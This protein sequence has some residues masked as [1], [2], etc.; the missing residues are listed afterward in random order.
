MRVAFLSVKS[1]QAVALRRRLIDAGHCLS[2]CETLDDLV[3]A[4]SSDSYD[5]LVVIEQTVDER[6]L[7]QVAS[8]RGQR[9]L[10]IPLILITPQQGE[11][12]VVRALN[13]GADDYMASPVREAE[14]LARLEALTRRTWHSPTM[15]RPIQ[16]GR[17]H[18]DLEIRRILLDGAPLQMTVKDFDLAVLLL[19][20]VGRLIS[21]ARIAQTVWGKRRT[22][23]SRTVDTHISRV[24]RT[25]LLTEANGWKLSAVHR[26]GYR[27]ERLD[28]PYKFA[29]PAK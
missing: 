8:I 7:E 10:D 26:R 14:F 12:F 17:L 23:T 6:G 1:V 4:F 27:L 3:A 29:N 21:R 16:A 19:R 18:V 5:A 13:E 28:D 22:A 9:K 2:S 24:R 20:N 11:N 25:L 15:Y